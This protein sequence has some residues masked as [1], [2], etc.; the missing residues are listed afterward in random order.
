MKEP[1]APSFQETWG[2]REYIEGWDTRMDWQRP[3][4]EMQLKMVDLMIPQPE[5]A[6]ITILDL[7]AGYGS[8]ALFLLERRPHSTALCIDASEEM[9]SMGR[10]RAAPL[11]K[12]VEFAYGSLESPQWLKSV[13]GAF[14]AAVSS[15]ALHHFTRTSGGVRFMPRSTTCCVR[16]AASLTPTT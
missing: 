1:K 5:D 10:E 2:K 9:L 8:L 15:R 7:C 11:G 12:R 6:S 14:D 13:S 4:R 3:L 16:A